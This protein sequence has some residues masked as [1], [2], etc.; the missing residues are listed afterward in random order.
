MKI[1][2]IGG[3]INGLYLA[4][5][6]SEKGH[7]ITVF[8]RKKQ[9]GGDI[10]CS[11]LFSSRILD[12]I[13]QAE[14]LIKNRI[15][16]VNIHFPKRNI[17][18][19]YSREFYIIEHSDLNK[20]SADLAEKNGVEIILNYN[21]TEIPQGFDK[22]IGCDGANSV[23]R[24]KLKMRKLKTK[25]GILG[26]IEKECFN[27]CVEAWPCSGGFIWRIPRGNNIEY[28]I[29]ADK[30]KAKEIFDGFLKE[31]ALSL[32][33]IKS[34]LIPCNVSI[35]NN[36]KITVCGDAAG[37][38]KPWSGGGVIWGLLAADMLLKTFPDFHKYRKKANNFFIPKI[39]LSK[40]ALKIVYFLGF[41]LSWILLKNNKIESDFLIKY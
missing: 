30:N 26:F 39:I 41:H 28:G 20:I 17:N 6:L 3:D 29:M 9:I 27:N 34:R 32:N 12:F 13:P 4:W 38:T 1:A 5:K 21:I 22:V 24:N 25:L 36:P 31:K 7:R 2:I 35:P 8:E 15:K 16:S 40:T 37:L 23:I 33:N 10:I 11:G 18:V 19:S 14:K